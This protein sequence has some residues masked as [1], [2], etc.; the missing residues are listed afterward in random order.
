DEVG[1]IWH[2]VDTLLQRGVVVREIATDAAPEAD[3]A[4]LDKRILREARA[5]ARIGHPGV[6]TLFDVVQEDGRTYII[7]ERTKAS[8]L[9]EVVEADGPRPARDCAAIGTQLLAALEVAHRKGIVHHDIQ[10]ANVLIGEGGAAKPTNFSVALLPEDLGLPSRDDPGARPYRPPE[11][12]RGTAEGDLW[13]LGATLHF[14]AEGDP[15]EDDAEGGPEFRR[16]GPLGGVIRALLAASPGAAPGVAELRE[17]LDQL[18]LRER[19]SE[20]PELVRPVPPG[21]ASD[22][23]PPAPAPPARPTEA[24]PA[25]PARPGGP[26]QPRPTRAHEPAPPAQA[27]EPATTPPAGTA[28]APATPTTGARPEPDAPPPPRGAPPA[29]PPPPR[30]TPPPPHPPGRPPA[31]TRPPHRAP[32]RPRPPPRLRRGPRSRPP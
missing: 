3:R 2:G 4:A 8:T 12:S 13:A 26:A 30:G 19:D 23:R 20:R 28:P 15:P 18:V 32:P 5:T 7:T 6:V 11:E 14:A 27:D 10:P 22:R 24:T 1:A 21:P 16:A 29:R 17:Q 9:L 25:P 31:R